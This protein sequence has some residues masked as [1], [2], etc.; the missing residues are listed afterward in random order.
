MAVASSVGM[1]ELAG[2]TKAFTNAW[3]VVEALGNLDLRIGDGEFVCV[4]GPSG[5]GKTTLL[6]LVAGLERPDAG[7]VRVDG[8][9]VEGPGPD[10][11]V[12]FQ[13]AALF[14]WL[15]VA[16]NV[17]FGMLLRGV[18]R[19]ERAA[20]AARWLE[21]VG[22]G[23][24]G[25]ARVH[26]LSGG[27]R[28]RVALA[29]ALALEPR[30]LLADEPFGA[31]DVHARRAFHDQLERLWMKTGQI[32]VF[33]THDVH[34]AVRLASRVLVLGS[35]PSRVRFEHAV[36]VERPRLADDPAL[37]EAAR[38]VEAHIEAP[39]A[40]QPCGPRPARALRRRFATTDR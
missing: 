6:N 24:F 30:T 35:R 14:P 16:E 34:E 19:R 26:E 17:A 2:V 8:R 37:A 5:C 11:S 21:A 31:L 39:Q 10:R 3:G 20:R 15:T 1:I 9:R 27:M 18:P 29:R 38:L 4:V 36:A 23:S 28:Q 25:D 13:D 7:E 33:I 12:L 40:P 32:V 22:L